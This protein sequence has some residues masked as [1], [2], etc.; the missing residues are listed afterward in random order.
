MWYNKI[1]RKINYNN[2]GGFYMNNLQLNIND[3]NLRQIP[4]SNKSYS[5]SQ[6]NIDML[7]LLADNNNSK[8]SKVLNDILNHVLK[9]E[10][11]ALNYG[12][13]N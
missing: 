5:L 3:L 10:K 4:K 7:E 6:D 12:K 1:G 2:Q 13:Y 9:L 11:E 8:A